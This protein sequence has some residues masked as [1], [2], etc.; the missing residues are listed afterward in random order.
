MDWRS[1]FINPQ[2][3]HDCY[4][5][6]PVECNP[7]AIYKLLEIKPIQGVSNGDCSHLKFIFRNNKQSTCLDLCTPCFDFTV[8]IDHFFSTNLG[9]LLNRWRG[10]YCCYFNRERPAPVWLSG[11]SDLGPPVPK[12]T[13]W[14]VEC[15]PYAL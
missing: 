4:M 2:I 10:F 8:R 1:I 5:N 14:N 15:G 3:C 7:A 9:I 12:D 13:F 11:L 6:Y